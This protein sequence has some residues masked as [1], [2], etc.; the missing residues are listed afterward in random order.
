MFWKLKSRTKEESQKTLGRSHPSKK[1]TMRE[2]K[3]E[4]RRVAKFNVA[5]IRKDEL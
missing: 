2:G 4:L 1:N 5:K 3:K